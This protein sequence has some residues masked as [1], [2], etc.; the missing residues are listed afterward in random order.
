MQ[1]RAVSR[2]QKIPKTRPEYIKATGMAR[3]PDPR[4]ALSKWVSVSLSLWGGRERIRG[5]SF[6]NFLF[7]ELT[8]LDVHYP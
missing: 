6:K 4:D 7:V 5:G 8:L 3:I 1:T 2:V